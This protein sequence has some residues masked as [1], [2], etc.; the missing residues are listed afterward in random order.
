MTAPPS[1]RPGKTRSATRST[2]RSAGPPAPQPVLLA[3][4]RQVGLGRMVLPET[5]APNLCVNLV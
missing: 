5:E 1:S 3:F 2:R 4:Y